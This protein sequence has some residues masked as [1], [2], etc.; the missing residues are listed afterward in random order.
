MT[1]FD[2]LLEALVYAQ[3]IDEEWWEEL[4]SPAEA[5]K[6]LSEAETYEPDEYDITQLADVLGQDLPSNEYEISWT[7]RQCMSV[8]RR[9]L[10]DSQ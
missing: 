10:R 2:E 9:Q 4:G 5:E 7:F 8:L 6:M 3:D 1:A